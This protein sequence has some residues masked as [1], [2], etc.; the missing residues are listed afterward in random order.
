MGVDGEWVLV[1]DYQVGVFA[2]FQAAEVLL[3]ACRVGAAQGVVAQ[4]RCR[5]DALARVIAV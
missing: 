2:G 1:Q 4:G 3:V 5:I